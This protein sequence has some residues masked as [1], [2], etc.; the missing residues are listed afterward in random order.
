MASRRAMR[1]V[2]LAMA[3]TALHPRS[4]AARH[5]LQGG[6]GGLG[7]SMTIGPGGQ[8]IGVGGAA[9][10]FISQMMT[11]M[12]A[13][14]LMEFLVF[15]QLKSAFLVK[16]FITVTDSIVSFS[17]F[18][19]TSTGAVV[20]TPG[21]VWTD[22]GSGVTLQMGVSGLFYVNTAANLNGVR[23]LLYV[24]ASLS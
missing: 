1:M 11:A 2:A 18:K 8:L 6:G 12:Q 14:D 23:R 13:G 16:E 22:L 10:S 21:D 7:S 3:A 19:D 9:G 20:V 17:T 4:C 5:L 15:D 24:P